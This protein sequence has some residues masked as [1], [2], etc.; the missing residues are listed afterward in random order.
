MHYIFRKSDGTHMATA[1]R[2]GDV[3]SQMRQTV[4]NEGGVRGDFILI[5]GVEPAAMG[6]LEPALNEAGEV[7][8]VPS[9]S[10][11]EREK[12]ITAYRR[13]TVDQKLAIMAR[14]LG[15]ISA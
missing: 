13:G 9:A 5:E 7:E 4:T 2:P 6:G 1:Y 15:L 11:L 8:F 3:E 14:R 10:A 12:D